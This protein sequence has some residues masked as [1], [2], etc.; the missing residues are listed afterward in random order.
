MAF[1]TGTHLGPY[2]NSPPLARAG[3]G[4]VYRARNTKLNRD[5]ALKIL[6]DA[7]VSDPDRLT[8]FTREAQTLASLNHRSSSRVYPRGQF[9]HLIIWLSGH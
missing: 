4:E 7:F 8:R 3:L 1:A 9:R 6:P 2:E 5:V